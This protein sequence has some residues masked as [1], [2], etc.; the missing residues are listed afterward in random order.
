VAK[1]HETLPPRSSHGLNPR[2]S[3]QPPLRPTHG[4][5]VLLT[6]TQSVIPPGQAVQSAPHSSRGVCPSVAHG[7][8]PPLPPRYTVYWH[9]NHALE[10]ATVLVPLIRQPRRG[11]VTRG[12]KLLRSNSS[13]MSITCGE[14]DSRLR[15]NE[16]TGPPNVT[17]RI[18]SKKTKSSVCRMRTRLTTGALW[19]HALF[20]RVTHSQSVRWRLY[21]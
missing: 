18:F 11:G 13:Y 4:Y 19:R 20:S 2:V 7:T 1:V 5:T 15:T 16:R 12:W 9:D 14:G 21:A 3:F 8:L 6:A 17:R 10:T